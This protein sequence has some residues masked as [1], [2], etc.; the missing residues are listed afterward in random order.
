MH[1][2]SENPFLGSLYLKKYNIISYFYDV[3]FLL[4]LKALDRGK[5]VKY[6][7]KRHLKSSVYNL[8][9]CRGEESILVTL[10]HK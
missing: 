8:W 10:Q 5:T 4:F 9:R 7:H 1:V 3:F 2:E 6:K